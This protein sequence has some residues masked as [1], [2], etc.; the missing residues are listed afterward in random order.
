MPISISEKSRINV[1]NETKQWSQRTAYHREGFHTLCVHEVINQEVM[2]AHIV[3]RV[4][5][6]KLLLDVGADSH[7]LLAERL[8][9]GVDTLAQL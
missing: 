8:D 9:V 1:S 6:E 4:I 5:S 7:V 3:D 2:L